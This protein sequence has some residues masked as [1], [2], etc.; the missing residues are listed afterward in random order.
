[1]SVVHPL[2]LRDALPIFRVSRVGSFGAVLARLDPLVMGFWVA[3]S[4]FKLAV[5]LYAAV[6]TFAHIFGLRDWRPLVLPLAALMAAYAVRSE[7]HTSELQSR[8][9]LV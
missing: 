9:T 1:A 8:E 4:C 3:G 5:T 6:I 2:S 7:G